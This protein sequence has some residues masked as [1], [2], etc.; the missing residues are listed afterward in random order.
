MFTPDVLLYVPWIQPWLPYAP[1]P[2]YVVVPPA[3]AVPGAVPGGTPG[4]ATFLAPVGVAGRLEEV[5]HVPEPAPGVA[6]AGSGISAATP[7]AVPAARKRRALMVM[8][9]TPLGEIGREV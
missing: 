2:A 1:A 5:V 9:C 6:F 7:S 4:I 8:D 3:H